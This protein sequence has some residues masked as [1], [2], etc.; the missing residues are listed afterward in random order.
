MRN[1]WQTKTLGDVCERVTVGHVG[2]TSPYYR[3]EGILFLRTQNVG[4]AGLVLDDRKYV[5]P[6]FHAS[7]KKSEVKAGDILMSRVITHTVHCALIPPD[8]GPANCANVVLVRAAS[9]LLPEFLAHYIRSSDAQRH[10][11]DRKVGSAQLVVN[12][13]V[14]QNWPIPVPPLLEQRRIAGFL[15]EASE[16]IATAKANAEKNLQNA[17]ALFESYL[18][19]VFSDC[20]PGWEEKRLGDVVTRLTNGYVGP[21]RNI[22][23]ESGVPYLLARHVKSNRLMFD[24]KTLISD[25]FN[26]KNKKSMLKAGDV[27]LVQSG[28][29]GHSAVV[30]EEHEGHNCHAMIVITPVKGALTGPFLSLFFNSSGMRQKFEEI[31]SGST[32]PHLT[33]HAVKELPIALPD[34]ATQKRLVDHSQELEAETRRLESIYRQKLAALEALKESLLHQA[35]SGKL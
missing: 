11:L 29:I 6:E 24:G 2:I 33:C 3:D 21:T 4:K 35:F 25:Q 27:L 32:V 12:T 7:L 17:R 20:R 16:G 26:R 22:Y 1:G 8:L 28:H 30:T 13:T 31:R 14:V 9:G 15:D 34:V 18:Q 19:A 5:T 10:L 23:V